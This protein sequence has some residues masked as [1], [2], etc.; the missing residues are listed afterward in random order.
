M[1]APKR[2]MAKS[3]RP[4]LVKKFQPPS[5]LRAPSPFKGEGRDGGW[6]SIA[7][8]LSGFPIRR[9]LAALVV[10]C[11]IYGGYLLAIDHAARQDQ[12]QPADAI[13]VLG[14]GV[15]ESGRPSSALIARIRYAAMLYHEGYAPIIALTGGSRD[16]RPAEA[17][18]AYRVIRWLGIPEEAI[19][20]EMT[21]QT[22]AQNVANIAPLLRERGVRSVIVVTS[23]FHALRSRVIVEG[24]GFTVY[25]SPALQ[26][27]AERRP[28]RRVYYILRE[29]ALIPVYLAFGL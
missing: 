1:T 4:S 23:P 11:V 7:R 29:S 5:A 16:G 6:T 3:N 17:E 27:P 22:T 25:M 26:D 19:L 9:A 13:L 12:R 2:L 14:G 10:V 8:I 21:S 20:I 18:V 15:A 28:W 24:E